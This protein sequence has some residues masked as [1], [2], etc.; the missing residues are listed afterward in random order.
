MSDWFGT[1]SVSSAINAGLSLEMPGPAVWRSPRLIGALISAHKIAP[2]ALDA[3]AAEVVGWVQRMA[4]LNPA[5]AHFGPKEERTRDEARDQDAAHLR[6]LAGEGIVLLKNEDSL[7]PLRG[8]VAVI[9]P[10]AKA[11]VITGGGSAQLRPAWAVSPWDGLVAGSTPSDVELSYSLG[12]VGAKFLPLLDEHFTSQDGRKGFDLNYYAINGDKIAETPTVRD[13]FDLSN[14]FLGDFHHPDLGK[15][16]VTELVAQFTAPISGMYEFGA[17][18]TGQGWVYV[19]D[20]LVVDNSK[21]Q[22]MGESFFNNGTVEV[23]G[24]VH[25]EEGKVSGKWG[26]SF[27]NVHFR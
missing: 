17:V 15:H 13:W 4:K 24:A 23:R 27:K 1:Y 11:A 3:R 18:V 5:L 8:K 16:F 14:M 21:N 7:L 26:E 20:E 22:V 6:R 10:N 19:D 12:C 9:G 25:V 2:E